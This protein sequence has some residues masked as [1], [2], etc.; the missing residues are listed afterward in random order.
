MSY[1]S[2]RTGA[3]VETL[4][5]KAETA[6][7]SV[8]SEYVTEGVLN[9]GLEGKVD[10]VNGKQLS[11]EDFTAEDKQKLDGLS[12]YDDTE[13]KAS[14]EEMRTIIGSHSKEIKFFC[15]EPVTVKVG[16]IEYNCEANQIATVFVGD[17]EFEIIP[18]SAKSI[19]SLLNYPIPLTWFDWL[20]GVDVFEN[21][22]FDM[23][24]LEMS[25]K[26]TQYHQG[27]Y[28][29]Q[30]AQYSNC[31]FWSDKPYTHSPFEERTNYTL[32]YTSQLPLCYATNPANTYKPFYFAYGVQN[33]PNWR[34]P[35]YINSFASLAS[36]APQTF[37]Y[38][39]AKAIGI[40][41]Y[42][43]DVI[44]LCKDARGLM[45]DS[46]A[47]EHAGIFDASNT[48]NFGAKKGSWQDAFGKCYSLTDL[49]IKNLKTSINVS[50]SPINN[51]SIEYIVNNA[52]NT[53]K[54]TISLSPYTWYR[55]TD[56]IRETAKSKNIT[57]ELITTNY[58]DDSRWATKQDTI[59]D[60]DTIR[61]GAALGATA[62]Q[63]YTEQYKGTVTG[64]K[65][66]GSTHNPSNGVV[67][68][69]TISAD[70]SLRIHF[71]PN[72]DLG[73]GQPID[74]TSL[75][76][77]SMGITPAELYE[78]VAT[79][80][81]KTALFIH[82]LMGGELQEIS[83]VIDPT[84]GTVGLSYLST[85]EGL[86]S[87]FQL[88]ISTTQCQLVIVDM[89]AGYNSVVAPLTEMV[90]GKQEQLV[91]GTNIKTI[92]GESILGSGNIEVSYDDPELKVVN[93]ESSDTNVELTPYVT[94]KWGTISSLTLTF[95][96]NTESEYNVVFEA[97]DADF[98]LSIPQN[99]RW[100]NSQIPQFEAK[101]QYEINIKG[102]RALYAV[103][104]APYI[105]GTFLE[106]IENDGVDYILTDIYITKSMSGMR[107]KSMILTTPSSNVALAGT[108]NTSSG[109]DTAPFIMWY[110]TSGRYLYWDG[111]RISG[112]GSFEPNVAYTD[113]HSG[114]AISLD[115]SYPI[116][117]FGV[118]NQGRV[119]SG[120]AF[121]LYYLELLDSNGNPIVNLCPF[122]RTYDNAIGLLDKVSG[123]FYPSN[124]GNL[125]GG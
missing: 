87:P 10:K 15:I 24:T 5:N 30:K 107:C 115:C 49:F 47:I 34:N 100:A 55:L 4:L 90:E 116:A 96:E 62:L 122:K 39:G 71:E 40:Y 59:A 79:N 54:I 67:D 109:T 29:V 38:Y 102:E 2:K 89:L 72:F 65:V 61:S 80:E 68:L 58:V 118:N 1:N 111:V 124:N 113:E 57:L 98:V 51:R 70:E 117:I 64:I 9:K 78:E 105:E 45:Y 85:L 56:A 26:W 14:I 21:I 106:Y 83:R 31:I 7:Q 42:D 108:R 12:N 25:Q 18:T 8:P 82:E 22:I 43:V 123:T 88:I 48:T 28:H 121:R 16:G 99:I 92:N 73:I 50:W 63:S 20:E 60:L 95:S 37:S 104:D 52:I 32:Y 27:D 91:S 75:V 36:G 35:D 19:K 119:Q 76:Q 84:Y 101:K 17:E 44:K 120:S 125:I 11:T 77:Q 6:L 23:N 41:N 93:H 33:D 53:S 46:S 69:G 86:P 81:K 74:V 103:F 97:N 94:H 3:E 112:F 110:L 114:D 66:N 13:I